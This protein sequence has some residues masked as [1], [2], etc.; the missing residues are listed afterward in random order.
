MYLFIYTHNGDGTFQN[1]SLSLDSNSCSAGHMSPTICMEAVVHYRRHNNK[2]HLPLSC[3]KLIHSTPSI[4]L[5]IRFYIFHPSTNSSFNWSLYV[6]FL[7]RHT[8]FIFSSPIWLT[9]T[10]HIS[11]LGLI[12]QIV[13]KNL[14]NGINVCLY[15]SKNKTFFCLFKASLSYIAVIVNSVFRDV[16]RFCT[17]IATTIIAVTTYSSV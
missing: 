2:P 13:F 11:Q 14:L 4:L 17:R 10:V 8:I 12:L 16:P 6:R 15:F 1:P 7:N 9:W 3:A 5:R